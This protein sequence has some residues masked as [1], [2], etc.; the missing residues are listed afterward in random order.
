MISTHP[1]YCAETVQHYDIKQITFLHLVIW[2]G[3]DARLPTQNTKF[4]VGKL[5][6]GGQ[7]KENIGRC[8]ADRFLAHPLQN[9]CQRPWTTHVVACIPGQLQEH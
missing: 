3:N 1:G 4:R 2:V 6:V 5:K 8:W 9:T 7:I